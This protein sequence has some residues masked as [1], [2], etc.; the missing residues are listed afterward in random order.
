MANFKLSRKITL[1]PIVILWVLLLLVSPVYAQT[2]EAEEDALEV[3]EQELQDEQA[4]VDEINAPRAEENNLLR[5]AIG[6]TQ[7]TILVL[8]PYGSDA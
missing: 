5:Q 2:C 7:D 1:S 3:A 4:R 6:E 8:S